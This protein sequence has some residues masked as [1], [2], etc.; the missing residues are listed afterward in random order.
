VLR[1]V[2]AWREGR[3]DDAEQWCRRAH[4]LAEQVGWS[5]V[6]FSALYWLARALRDSGDYTG[7]ITE[8][9]R[10]LDVCERA[11]LIAQSIEAMSARAVTLVIAG[12][13]E[14][15]RETAEEAGHLAN[16]LHYPVGSAA[17]LMAMG[18]TECD[19]EQAT[20]MMREAKELWE[21]I[22]RPL[23]AAIADLLLGHVLTDCGHEDGRAVLEQ[24][25]ADFERLGVPHLA[26]YAKSK[27]VA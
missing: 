13:K 11:G 1:G 15:A 16:R 14:Q 10:A 19:S 27:T 25:A 17:A 6:S 20:G 18:T 4:E 2:L 12:K 22:G 9:D 3:W 24:A 7:A 8:L 23:D 5:E 21:G 26:E